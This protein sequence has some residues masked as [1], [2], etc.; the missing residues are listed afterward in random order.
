MS[1]EVPGCDWGEAAAPADGS[2]TSHACH[3]PVPPL[4]PPSTDFAID[5]DAIPPTSMHAHRVPLTPSN[6][7]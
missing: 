5:S 1:T 3:E 7:T 2:Y 4:F 6:K